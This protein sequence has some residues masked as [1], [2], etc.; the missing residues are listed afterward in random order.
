MY[1]HNYTISFA[2]GINTHWDNFC[3]DCLCLVPDLRPFRC[4]NTSLARIVICYMWYESRLR[5]IHNLHAKINKRKAFSFPEWGENRGRDRDTRAVKFLTLHN[6]WKEM[7]VEIE[8]LAQ[9]FIKLGLSSEVEVWYSWWWRN[10]N[11]LFHHSRFWTLPA[12]QV[13]WGKSWER[14]V[15]TR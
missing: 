15:T 8:T 2:E 1:F 13:W 6:I 9:Q 10:P 3:G 7:D 5:I 4:R 12:E 11:K 14:Q